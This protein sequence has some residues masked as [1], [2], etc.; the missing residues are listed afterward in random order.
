MK[1]V[2]FTADLS[3]EAV[4]KI[5]EDIVAKLPKRGR[6]RVILLTPEDDSDEPE[7][8]LAAYDQFLREDPPEDLSSVP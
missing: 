1:A 2:E 6:V 5:P 7:W 4:L 8:R 3:Q